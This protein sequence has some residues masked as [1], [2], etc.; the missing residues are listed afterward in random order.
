MGSFDKGGQRGTRGG[1]LAP[2]RIVDGIS[3]E[4]V[5]ESYLCMFKYINMNMY[6]YIYIYTYT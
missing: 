1:G 4:K 5:F 6:I 2:Q 3:Q